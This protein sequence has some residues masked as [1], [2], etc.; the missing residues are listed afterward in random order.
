MKSFSSC[1]CSRQVREHG[2]GAVPVPGRGQDRRQEPGGRGCRGLRQGPGARLI[3]YVTFDLHPPPPPSTFSSTVHLYHMFSTFALSF[4]T[5]IHCLYRLFS[6]LLAFFPSLIEFKGNV[7]RDE[8][9]PENKI[10]KS[11]MSFTLWHN[12]SCIL[13]EFLD[14]ERKIDKRK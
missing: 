7:S 6:R 10:R 14:T 11:S 3:G 8:N 9:D 12:F 1:V 4:S 2:G 5:H 13:S